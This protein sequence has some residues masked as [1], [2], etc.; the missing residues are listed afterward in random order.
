MGIYKKL[1]A[2][3]VRNKPNIMQEYSNWL[4]HHKNN[5]ISDKPFEECARDEAIRMRDEILSKL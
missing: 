4:R 3:L 5:S 1:H 2:S